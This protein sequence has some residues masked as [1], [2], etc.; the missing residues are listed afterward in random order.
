M[1]LLRERLSQH[2][3]GTVSVGM[4]VGSCSLV[5]EPESRLSPMSAKRHAGSQLEGRK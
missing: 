5:V 2:S 3:I 4:N 1:P